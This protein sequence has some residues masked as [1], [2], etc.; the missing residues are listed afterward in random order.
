MS[1]DDVIH[2]LE[3]MYRGVRCSVEGVVLF[4]LQMLH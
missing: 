2:V 1:R 4:K 3:G